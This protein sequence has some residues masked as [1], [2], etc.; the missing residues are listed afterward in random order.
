M[1]KILTQKSESVLKGTVE[2]FCVERLSIFAVEFHVLTEDFGLISI[3]AG[4]K[5]FNYSTTSPKMH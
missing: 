1:G 5:L 3:F 2:L 4:T